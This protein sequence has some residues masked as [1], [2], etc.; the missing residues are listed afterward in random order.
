MDCASVFL[1]NQIF[2]PIRQNFY[3]DLIK[4]WQCTVSVTFQLNLSMLNV[5]YRIE[6]LNIYHADPKFIRMLV[7]GG[8]RPV[9]Q[10]GSSSGGGGGHEGS[11]KSKSSESRC[12]TYTNTDQSFLSQCLL[13][14]PV[15]ANS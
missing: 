12:D 9:I 15:R 3:V 14:D 13:F 4:R 7:D 1:V 11:S 6:H 8:A 2:L 5:F 10:S